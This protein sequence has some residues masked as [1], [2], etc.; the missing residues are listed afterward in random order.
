MNK[1]SVDGNSH[2]LGLDIGANSVGWALVRLDGK[3]PANV[4]RMGVRVFP[5]GV[6][7]DLATGREKSRAVKRREARLHRRM[8]D[9]QRRRLVRVAL[10]LQEAGLLPSGEVRL[11]S[12]R[13]AFF[14]S[15]DR[16]LFP[17]TARKEIPHVL[18]YALRA[19]A[20]DERLEPYEFGR[21]LY[22]LA[23][24][25]G[26]LSNR[27]TSS[28]REKKDDDEGVVKKKIGELAQR[29]EES[30]ARTLGEYFAGL[31]PTQERIRQRYTA[32]AMFDDE[33]K[34]IWEAQAPH[35]PTLLAEDLRKRLHRAVFFQ[36]PLKSAKHLIGQ[37][38]LER[39]CQR[40]PWP[41]LC[42]QRFRILQTVNILQVK[43]PNGT[44]RLLTPEERAKLV[45]ALDCNTSLT[46]AKIRRLLGLSKEYGFNMEEGGEKGLI[47]SKTAARLAEAVG[48]ERWKAWTT[49]ERDRAVGLIRSV[50]DRKTLARRAGKMLGLEEAAARRL[51]ETPLEDGYC[52]LSRQAIEKVLPLLE[53]GLPYAT[54]R[55]QLYGDK[56]GPKPVNVLPRLDVALEVR[57]PAV[58]RALTEVRKVVNAVVREYGKPAFIRIE[59]ARDLKKN[60]K[61]RAK[62]AQRNRQNQGARERA[63]EKIARE[64]GIKQPKGPDIEKVLLAEECGW[65]CPY[66][67]RPI[68]MEALLG[69]APQFDVE[70]IVP[71]SRCL[72]NSFFNK[73]L[74][75]A[76]ENRHRKHNRTPQEAYS[77]DPARWEEILHRVKGFQGEAAREKLAKF[78]QEGVLNLDDFTSRQLNDTRYASRLAVEYLS[79]LYG[80]GADGVDPGGTRR[81][82]AGRGQVTGYLRGEWGLNA[83][84]GAGP[85]K[86]RADHRQHAIDAVTIALTEA[87]TVKSLSDAAARAEV[88]GRRRF[89]PM[90]PPWSDFADDIRRDVEEMVVSHRVSRKVSGPMHEETVYSKPQRDMQG[91]LCVH[92]RKRLES[93][94]E[95]DI[96]DIVDPRIR[97]IVRAKLD[98]GKPEKVF[99]SPENHPAMKAR[100]GRLIPI[101][102]VRIRTSQSTVPISQG[103]R[104][105]QVKLGSN[106]HVEII[107]SKDK[108]GALRWEGVV[109]S[110]LE[111]MRRLRTGEP[112]VQRDHGE[113]KEFKFSLA[114]GEVIELDEDGSKRG[115]YVVRTVSQTQNAYITIEFITIN[116]A[117]KKEEIKKER[118]WRVKPLESLRKLNCYKVSVTPLGEVR[119]AG[120]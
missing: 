107:E 96:E 68:N 113:G 2:V 70:H 61:D 9:R 86:E 41:L 75:D 58:E 80:A 83:V 69:D 72:D 29:M 63:T 40:A 65:I 28:A 67:G 55:K 31:N 118:A 102:S 103:E 66:T 42:A 78:Q 81:V 16:A 13:M 12:D 46:W 8:L 109:V 60:R 84:L 26:F 39:G 36:R 57:N 11:S 45:G 108:K 62:I 59:L 43:E 51:A 101:H 106:H 97:D 18:L 64:I 82:Q 98:G 93:L 52:S 73:T 110:T 21:A 10:L 77:S 116:E 32:R 85:A 33:F 15:L 27:R 117:R 114:G 54:A 49:Q 20:L 115:L 22:H 38:E 99:T 44:N 19:R 24:R 3:R 90:E 119:R 74:C 5:E 105:R 111:A 53:Q 30:G 104:E 56:P 92:V 94:S 89:A 23:Q 14:T 71:F 34:Q 17:I 47:G 6:E 79:R 76:Q 35:H 91:K 120:D 25:R 95:A 1:L 4:E 50:H 37:C 100:D 7:G 48:E 112:I 88:S 87:A